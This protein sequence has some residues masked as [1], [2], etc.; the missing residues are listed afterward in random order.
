MESYI[1]MKDN[2]LPLY[3]VLRWFG[4]LG[5]TISSQVDITNT[6]AHT[7][8]HTHTYTLSLSRARAH[9]TMANLKSTHS[10]A[11]R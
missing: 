11:L 4:P 3:S 5:L 7:H 2:L 10:S 9:I 6:H 8:A 1:L